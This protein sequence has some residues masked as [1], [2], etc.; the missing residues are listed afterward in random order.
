[1]NAW[2]MIA[3]V[4]AVSLALGLGPASNGA[5]SAPGGSSPA[6]VLFSLAA[7]PPPPARA[8]A[9]GAPAAPAP[10]PARLQ[11]HPKPLLAAGEVAGLNFGVW[12][13]LHYLGN[14]HYSYISWE[15]IRDNL[16]DGWEWDRSMYF[17]NFYHHPYHGYLY[18]NAGRANGLGFWG[19]SLC[20][21]GGSLMWEVM[22]EKYR[23]SINDLITTSTGGIAIGEVGFRFSA[24]VRKKGARGL[25]RVWREIV[26]TILD[27]VGGANRLLN[28]HKDDEP[29][30]PGSPDAGRILNGELLVTGPVI[31]RSDD[32]TGTRAAPLLGF[33][34]RY[35]DPAGTGWTG[36]PFD[37]FT[38]AGRL[39]W[40]PDKP[41]LSLSIQGALVGKA[42]AGRRGSSHFVGLYQHYEYYGI[43]TMRICGTSY[44]GGWTST[45][46]PG[47][48]ARITASARLGWLGLGGSDDFA[49]VPGERRNYNL[50]TG[51]TA[52][53]ELTLA[54]KGYEY[55]SAVWRHY[56]LFNLNVV[57]SRAGREHWNILQGQASVPVMRRVGLGFAAEYCGRNYVFE[58]DEPGS[59]HLVEARVFATWQF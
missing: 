50:A 21:L 19:S 12:A 15:T 29:W 37:V 24:L 49:N 42:I 55:F 35:G 34:L 36:R 11:F 23:P 48:E 47:R 10:P 16:R 2:P 53:A 26:G 33:T 18:Y 8:S 45:F 56:S 5:P 57:G 1:M 59:R 54:A 46:R 17:V 13:F 31:A 32:L 14:A 4:L 39:R 25:D 30:L 28:G 58:V 22:M 41:H 52:A 43:D 7:T 20:A 27:P 44:T 40:G 6:P 51:V 9:A 38:V 3:P